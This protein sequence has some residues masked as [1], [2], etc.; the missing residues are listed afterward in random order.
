MFLIE[1]YN[2]IGVKPLLWVSE[3]V[4]ILHFHRKE[5]PDT[6]AIVVINQTSLCV[7]VVDKPLQEFYAGEKWSSSRYHVEVRSSDIGKDFIVEL[8][9]IRVVVRS[10]FG[11]FFPLDLLE[12]FSPLWEYCLGPYACLCVSK[13]RRLSENILG[14]C[15]D[16]W[17]GLGEN[18]N[19]FAAAG[20]EPS[21]TP[22]SFFFGSLGDRLVFDFLEAS[23]LHSKSIL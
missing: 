22:G 1:V 16:D 15:S 10:I 11:K 18:S 21:P 17:F 8:S 4:V 7:H 5:N 20:E 3:L 2:K 23:F 6:L 14:G 13:G 9:R 12:K 19:C